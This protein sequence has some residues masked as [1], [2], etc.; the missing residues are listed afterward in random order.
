VDHYEGKQLYNHFDVGHDGVLRNRSKIQELARGPFGT[1]YGWTTFSYSEAGAH[2]ITFQVKAYANTLPHEVAQLVAALPAD[3]SPTLDAISIIR[4]FP[5]GPGFIV[6]SGQYSPEGWLDDLILDG[7]KDGNWIHQNR[8]DELDKSVE[9]G[10]YSDSDLIR[11]QS[12]SADI[13]RPQFCRL[14]R[15]APPSTWAGTR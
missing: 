7:A 12:V 13:K 8:I 1:V 4:V 6:V 10:P 11:Y 3:H 15:S 5:V 14:C 9:A 2:A